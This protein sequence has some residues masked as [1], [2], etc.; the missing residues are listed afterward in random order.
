MVGLF[1]HFFIEEELKEINRNLKRK[2]LVVY[3]ILFLTK[4]FSYLAEP[5]LEDMEDEIHYHPLEVFHANTKTAIVK[6]IKQESK[7]VVVCKLSRREDDESD[8]LQKHHTI[9]L[10][11]LFDVKISSYYQVMVFPYYSYTL[12]SKHH[13]KFAPQL[14]KQLFEVQ[15]KIYH[16]NN[17]GNCVLSL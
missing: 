6:A 13:K 14:M 3:F 11:N 2:S 1:S 17:S 15:A 8:I 7:E 16:F 10:L 9:Q 4:K 12:D 5:I